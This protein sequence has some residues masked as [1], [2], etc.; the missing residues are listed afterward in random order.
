[1][2]IIDLE[3]SCLDNL[4]SWL[5][6]NLKSLISDSG[7][8]GTQVA[9]FCSRDTHIDHDQRHRRTHSENHFS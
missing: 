8:L 1:M 5:Y 3:I 7:G 9:V 2:S 4:G 6:K